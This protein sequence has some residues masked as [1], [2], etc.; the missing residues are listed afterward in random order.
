MLRIR[1]TRSLPSL[2]LLAMLLAVPGGV[3][4][5]QVFPRRDAARLQRTLYEFR[6]DALGRGAWWWGKD[7][8]TTPALPL[9]RSDGWVFS[10][11]QEVAAFF[12]GSWLGAPGWQA[13]PIVPGQPTPAV[14][15]A[16]RFTAEEW[17]ALPE[18]ERAAIRADMASWPVSFGAPWHDAD[19]N[20]RYEPD[21]TAYP[22]FTGDAPL[23]AGD[24][25]VWTATHDGG[26]FASVAWGQQEAGLE[27]RHY[28]WAMAGADCPERVVLQR[29]RVI[30]RA[31]GLIKEMRLGLYADV[32]LGDP[33]DDLVG[34]DSTLGLAF[35]WNSGVSDA[36]LGDPPAAGWLVLQGIA[37][38]ATGERGLFDFQL[39]E[40][41]RNQPPSAFTFFDRDGAYQPVPATDSATTP[42]VLRAALRGQR[43]D[44]SS[45]RDPVTGEQTRFAAA[46]NPVRGSGW[47]DGTAHAPGGRVLLLSFG[48]FMLARGDT[49]EVVF[50]RIGAQGG[51]D[52]RADVQALLDY[53]LCV[54]EHYAAQ[55]VTGMDALPFPSTGFAVTGLWP[56]P[57]A[58]G[59]GMLHVGLRS[60]APAR[61]TI[62]WRDLL[63]RLLAESA[64]DFP[65]GASTLA[66]RPPAGLRSGMFVLEFHSGAH[67]DTRLVVV[68]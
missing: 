26:E 60:P 10:A 14:F 36:L 29:L 39:R 20:G 35:A 48:P 21:T 30:N 42:L 33:A 51:A 65:I 11:E 2:L 24:E 3:V 5:A 13:G 58:A 15:H 43:G 22:A 64:H 41:I 56:Q 38:T 27:F 63:G 8:S 46:G 50:A 34:Y 47:V 54:R 1:T 28:V 66:I 62:R 23:P 32:A 55:F 59:S 31:A 19:G 53:A 16:G 61:T 7:T 67:R 12:G 18:A 17:D 49:Q 57:F 44:G 9:Q 6:F 68:R 25:A 40:G 45:Q 37:E 52:P 4:H